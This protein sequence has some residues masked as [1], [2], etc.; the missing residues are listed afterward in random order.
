MAKVK[1]TLT[2]TIEQEV[3]DREA[4]SLEIQG[5]LV[6]RDGRAIT[7]NVMTGIMAETEETETQGK[8]K[9]AP[10]KPAQGA[11]AAPTKGQEK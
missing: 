10:E 1:T 6:E 8:D 4:E 3:P 9:P 2:P 11:T 5:L 7:K